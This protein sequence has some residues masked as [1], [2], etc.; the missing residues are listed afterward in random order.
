MKVVLKHR[1]S[2]P[3]ARWCEPVG[4]EPGNKIE[5]AEFVDGS[6]WGADSEEAGLVYFGDGEEGDTVEATFA[7]LRLVSCGDCKVIG[8]VEYGEPVKEIAPGVYEAQDGTTIVE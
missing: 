1:S 4:W 7:D 5:G 6:W 8:E 3:G 2:I